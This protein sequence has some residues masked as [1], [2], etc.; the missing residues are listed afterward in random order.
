MVSGKK[1][2]SFNSLADLRP[3]KNNFR[4]KKVASK[5]GG[6][7]KELKALEAHAVD[8]LLN[9]K[10]DES[11]RYYDKFIE[12]QQNKFTK[13]CST[14]FSNRGI[15]NARLGNIQS[16]IEDFKMAVQLNKNHTS[17]YNNLANIYLST[18]QYDKAFEAINQALRL[19]PNHYNANFNH[20]LILNKLKRNKEAIE[21]I[22][23]LF[24]QFPNEIKAV[25][26]SPFIDIKKQVCDWEGIEE[27]EQKAAD[28][29]DR[30]KIDAKWALAHLNNQA[31]N[32]EQ[33]FKALKKF[34]NQ[35]FGHLSRQPI[36]AYN[37]NNRKIKVAYVSADFYDHATTR[38]MAQLFENHDK[39]LFEWYAISHSLDDNSAMRRRV[40]KAFDHFIDVNSWT[41]EQ[42]SLWM[43]EQQID[44]AVDLKGHTGNQ[45]LGIFAR[46][47]AP[48]QITYIGFPGSTG[49]NFMDYIIGDKWV[50]PLS[51]KNQFSEAILQLPNCY[52]PNDKQRYLPPQSLQNVN[53]PEFLA[54]RKQQRVVE[55]LPEKALVLCCFNNTYKL[56]PNVFKIWMRLLEKH[57]NGVLWLLADKPLTEINLKQYA[58][59]YGID[60]KRIH[61]APRTDQKT[62]LSRYLLA[63]LFVD[64]FA[65]NAHTTG[66]DALW[67]GLPM[68][69]LAGPS[70]A[71][72]VGASLLDTVGLSELITYSQNDYEQKIN[73]LMTDP[74]KLADLSQHLR[75]VRDTTPLFNSKK[76]AQ[77]L[78]V[79]YQSVVSK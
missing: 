60:E 42:V 56:H 10:F 44:I 36:S 30:D 14:A 71:S 47:C 62:Y 73:E 59:S 6:L 18:G 66:S 19:D 21:A 31:L 29:I 28:L 20:I 2:P 72:R 13:D 50:T 17:A 35:N 65:Y 7:S 54:W 4:T 79:L 46:G 61:F 11:K 53:N 8:A 25:D 26:P 3:Q 43:R 34:S 57:P 16:A 23:K 33:Q 37:R 38:L 78:E 1:L 9:N 55:G 45:R 67:I 15:I 64:T 51:A 68:V 69:T 41:D 63:D 32:G 39:Q 48:V 70:F 27:L 22:N 5:N 74:Q 77:D 52:Q 12:L 49:S 75:N 58:K 24:I 76:T 40:I